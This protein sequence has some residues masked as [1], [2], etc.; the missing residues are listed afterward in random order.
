M[1]LYLIRHGKAQ[2]HGGPGRDEDRELVERGR[3]QAR[4]LGERLREGDR[5]PVVVLAS[6]AARALQTGVLIG[7]GLGLAAV[8]E[9]R[10]GLGSSAS[11]VVELVSELASGVGA[12][13]GGSAALVGHNP[14]MSLVVQ[15]LCR[16]PSGGDWIE[17]RTGQAAVI[18]LADAGAPLGMGELLELL[19]GDSE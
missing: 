16:G 1:R 11:A 19:R 15:A 5:P 14:T 18:E 13:S 4:W 3:Q 10:L 7:E 6:P 8:V 9:E 12:G 2:R 17:L